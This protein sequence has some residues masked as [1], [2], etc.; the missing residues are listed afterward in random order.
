M[1]NLSRVN[2]YLVLSTHYCARSRRCGRPMSWWPPRS[3]TLRRRRVIS[4]GAARS[5]SQ[6]SRGFSCDN[7]SASAARWRS[8]V[9]MPAYRFRLQRGL[10]CLSSRGAG[11][12]YAVRRRLGSKSQTPSGIRCSPIWHTTVRRDYLTCSTGKESSTLC[13]QMGRRALLELSVFLETAVKKLAALEI[14]T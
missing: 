4:C 6:T 5:A 9:R 8:H 13:P 3:Q 14:S 12:F 11:R 7:C 10:R 1:Q 2:R